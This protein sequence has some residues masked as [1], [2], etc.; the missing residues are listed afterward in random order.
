MVINW[1]CFKIVIVIYKQFAM[2]TAGK[3]DVVEVRVVV[4][5]DIYIEMTLTE[6]GTTVTW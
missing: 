4:K 1:L 6:Q 5:V 3:R 2:E